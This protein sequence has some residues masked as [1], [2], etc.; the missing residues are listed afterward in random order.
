[1]T[2]CSEI[3]SR[4]HVL[5]SRCTNSVDE[6]A[7]RIGEYQGWSDLGAQTLVSNMAHLAL[8]VEGPVALG[9]P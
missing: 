3:K 1:M 9:R 2:A 8:R 4:N 5:T 7:L 6:V